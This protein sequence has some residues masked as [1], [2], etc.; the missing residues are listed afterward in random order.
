MEFHCSTLILPKWRQE[1]I[2]DWGTIVNVVS[3]HGHQGP[4]SG[5]FQDR[6]DLGHQQ[7][8][9]SIV[10]GIRGTICLIEDVIESV[11]RTA[12]AGL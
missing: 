1:H 9:E 4:F 6:K 11:R 2:T 10:I 12:L 5:H 7:V 8:K 3:I